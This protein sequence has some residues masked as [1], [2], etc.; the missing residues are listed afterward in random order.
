MNYNEVGERIRKIRETELKKT[1]EEFAE[2]IGIAP[3]TLTRLENATGKVSNIEFFIKI[4]ELTGYSLDELTQDSN[5]Y[6]KEKEKAIKKINY[7]L[8]IVSVDELEYIYA[9]A[10]R[11]IQFCH[12][13]DIKTLKDIKDDFKNQ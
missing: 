2:E 5:N 9:S 13:N 10:R 12:Q 4:S 11:F 7:L 3:I 1:R 8:N 6:S